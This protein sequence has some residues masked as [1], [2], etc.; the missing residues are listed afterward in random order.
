MHYVNKLTFWTPG[1]LHVKTC[2]LQV[3]ETQIC[4]HFGDFQNTAKFVFL[5][6]C[7]VLFM[8][9]RR[10][11]KDNKRTICEENN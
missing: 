1:I 6:A 9:L 3:G 11:V 7:H 4:T 2:T 5:A 10:R 8:T